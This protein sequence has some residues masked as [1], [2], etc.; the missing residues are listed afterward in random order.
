MKPLKTNGLVVTIQGT[1][2]LK[3][4]GGFL[5]FLFMI[6]S[7]SGALTS[8]KPEYRISSSSVNTA[9]TNLTGEMLYHFLG[10]EN[11][12][13]LEAMPEDSFPPRFANV[14]FKLS[15]NVN[16]DDPRSLL[17]RELPFFSLY[18]SK[19]LVA[20]EGTD[21]TNMP[22][23]SSP[24]LE[25]L[26]AEQEAALQNTEG[27]D[28]NE[29]N[30]QS[31]TPPMTTGDKKAVYVYFSHNR[32]SFL[33]YLKGVN[34]PNAA[35]HSQ[36]NVTKI[37]DKLKA[38]LESRGIGTTV[39]KTDIQG[40]LNKKGWSYAQSYEASRE[41][42]QAAASTDRDLTYFIDIHRDS[43][44]KEDTTKEINGK[45]YA[46][47][48]F[49]IGAEHQNYE[50]NLKFANELHKR[51][52][53]K[54]KGLSRGIIQ[55]QGERTNGKFNQDLSENA[56]LIE[57]GGVDNTFEEL[58]RSAEALAE[59]FSEYYWQAEEVNSTIGGESEKK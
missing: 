30:S 6:F 42:V 38:E 10:W 2:L 56:I 28:S 27:L 59:I 44:R 58:D 31:G 45:T 29:E 39:D 43:R 12:A 14:V 9:A 48:A 18:D 51:L 34:D 4:I 55:L 22:I 54:Y 21:Y 49:V 3:A 36:I 41:V 25:V 7:I 19:I 5:L 35:S 8:L 46:K 13:F 1:S 32:E 20:G 52:E 23:E 26:K 15:T 11:H 37:G 16:L 57:F 40:A 33:P 24:P 50:K 53:D 17:G 47:L